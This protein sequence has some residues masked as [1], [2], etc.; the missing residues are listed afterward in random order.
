MEEYKD[1]DKPF[2]E[3][4]KP[5]PGP[6]LELAGFNSFDRDLVAS[7][8]M[9]FSKEVLTAANFLDVESLLE[10]AAARIGTLIK[11]TPIKKLMEMVGVKEFTPEWEEEVRRKNPWCK[12][13]QRPAAGDQQ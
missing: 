13:I 6:D 7:W 1:G 10:L 4:R 9:E 2:S 3:L 8:T 11:G 5:V 12:A